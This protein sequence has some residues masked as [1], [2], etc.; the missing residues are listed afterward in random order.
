M[1][2]QMTSI[3][4]RCLHL[5]CLLMLCLSLQ[6][7]A[8][9][10]ALTPEERECG[11][12]QRPDFMPPMDYRTDRTLLENVEWNHFAPQVQNLV[13][14]MFQY[15]GSDISYTLHAFPNHPKALITLV[16]LGDRE[17]TDQPKGLPYPIECFFKR[18]VRFRP[19][20]AVVRMLYAQFLIKTGRP[21]PAAAHLDYVVSVAGDNMLT[22]FNAGLLYLEMKDYDKAL[23]LSH[24]LEGA[25]FP[26]QDLK[27]RLT[28]AGQWRPAPA[29]AVAASA[30]SG[31]ASAAS[32]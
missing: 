20:D 8:Q 19:D 12:L 15:F 1:R 6:A 21:Q 24:K 27:Q 29:P 16:R 7:Q 26:R 10:R 5:A 23:A 17:G 22:Y 4:S 14:P 13:K 9:L 31:P 11:L 3:A 25:D 28:T 2:F 18:A 32:R 30:A